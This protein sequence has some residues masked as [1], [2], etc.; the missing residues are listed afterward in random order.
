[1][2]ETIQLRRDTAANW[3]SVNPVLAQCEAGVE[4][5]TGK[6]K[7]G[8]GATAWVSLPY[9]NPSGIVGGGGGGGGA[10]S[11]VFG[12]TGAVAATSG[13]YSVGQVTGA[14]PLA[15]PALAGT[16]T[17]PT[18]A[19]LT[20]STQAAST[21]YADSA[22]A[23]E[24]S[25]AE[26][27]EALKAPLASPALTG[28]PTAPTQAGSDNSTK[29]A[30]TAY[31]TAAVATETT[32]AEAAESANA[33]SITSEASRAEAAEALLAP[34][35]NPALTGAPT[36]PTASALT[37]STQL[38]TTAYADSAVSVEKSRAQGA[39]ALLASLASPALTGSPTTPTQT[40]GDNTTKIATDQFVTTAV[41]AETS[42]AETAEAGLTSLLTR[43]LV[44]AAGGGS[45]HT[46]AAWEITAVDTTSGNCTVNLPNGPAAGVLNA[47]K[48]IVL[49]TGYSVTVQCQGSDVINAAGGVTTSSLTL[50]S[51]GSLL[52]Y[53][54][55]GT[56]HIWTVLSDDLPLSQLDNR[57]VDWI[58]VKGAAY[59][60]AG[61]TK[62]VADG[63]ITASSATLTSASANFASADAGKTIQVAGAGS[64]PAPAAPALATAIT[65][66]TVLAGVYQVE[67]TYVNASGETTAS[68]SA[69]ITT[70]GSTST[71]TIAS[72]LPTG[73]ASGWYAYVTQVNGSSYTRQQ[74]PGS[75]SGIAASLVIAAPPT[76]TGLAPPGSNTATGAA[77]VTSISG[78]TNSTTVTLT[79]AAT[80]T[81]S[82]TSTTYGTDDTSALNS[83]LSAAN[84]AGGGTV[85]VP[86]G[87]Y[88]TSAVLV[89]YSNTR[90]LLSPDAVI[91]LVDGSNCT[92]LID[93]AHN[94]GTQT[95]PSPVSN[96]TVEGGTWERNNNGGANLARHTMILGGYRL[97]VR[98][99]QFQ[100]TAASAGGKYALNIQNA[101]SFTIEN[102]KGWYYISD[103]VHVTGPAQYGLIRNIYG[104]S[105]KDDLIA[106]TTIDSS[107]SPSNLQFGNESDISDIFVEN[108]F[109]DTQSVAQ[110]VGIYSG[111]SGSTVLNTWR[112]KVKNIHGYLTSG[113]KAPVFIGDFGAPIAGGNIDDIVIDGIDCKVQSSTQSLVNI[114]S[115]DA[116]ASIGV[117]SVT[118]R[119]VTVRCD[120]EAVV[121]NYAALA[122]L[123]VEGV[124][125]ATAANPFGG[126]LIY[127]NGALASITRLNLS[128][129]N[130]TSAGTQ[131]SSL[132]SAVT[133][134]QVLTE[135]F[136]D[137]IWFS[138]FSYLASLI[139]TT[140]MSLSN[141]HAIGNADILNT[142]TGAS[143]TLSVLPG[144][145]FGTATNT[146]SGTVN[147]YV[148]FLSPQFP[149][150]RVSYNGSTYV[151]LGVTVNG[152]LV[153]QNGYLAI[154]TATASTLLTVAG[155]IA[156]AEVA[157]A[158]SYT[159]TA[160]D[161]TVIASGSGTVITLPTAAS[162]TGRQY[163]IKRSD[164]SNT[165]T[166]GTT[167]SQTID[168]STTLSLSSNY[169]AVTVQSDGSNWQVIG[170][171]ATSI[172]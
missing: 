41:T 28:S 131:G 22:V 78:F 120:L 172:L 57:Y 42:R 134:G 146:G 29:L 59:G 132:I 58:N 109:A 129:I 63:A 141:V 37:N 140:A 116:A 65:G 92:M 85:Y 75:P 136:M 143:V 14:A 80:T 16:P 48:Q 124:T 35:A 82:G 1:M 167:S 161:S 32:R 114:N 73:N 74:A 111:K 86:A 171:V 20:D 166:V 106:F 162:I 95:V 68:V 101:L 66:G 163:T 117:G 96:I 72:P 169:M 157:K 53:S 107:A 151:T 154:G 118:I 69:S 30:T 4:T 76:N 25:R 61:N 104:I 47:V 93:N 149:Q 156:T 15:S 52:H 39:E 27:A 8:D 45:T 110:A 64:L 71:I 21:A 126:A 128:D 170:Q 135:A 164:A 17:V 112:I 142:S 87:T 94:A 139:T 152:T 19:A 38:A 6:A 153:I 83:A 125:G 159:L 98:D 67:V 130:V 81:V 33:A 50:K 122:Y 102:I 46:A 3:V 99:V 24:T 5:D 160:T 60:A 43:V 44:T 158:S 84:T 113:A 9:W 36:A 121:N 145:T 147:Q 12:R 138:N 11:S 90:L 62:T 123:S 7:L 105:N 137:G 127:Q 103:L 79:A 91:S 49:G 155:P 31:A 144:C 119:N 40:T 88:S 34:K 150:I 23:V 55:T 133:S 2:I 108:V 10:V 100:A 13:D 115:I 26:A 97:T 89:I 54:G 70:T 168:G 18:A 77:L 56:G 51:Q 165:I 148:N